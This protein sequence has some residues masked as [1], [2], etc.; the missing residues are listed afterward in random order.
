MGHAPRS[1]GSFAGRR[2]NGPTSGCDSHRACFAQHRTEHVEWVV[3]GSCPR[4]LRADEEPSGE[5]ERQHV[6]VYHRSQGGGVEGGRSE[7]QAGIRE[8]TLALWFPKTGRAP[9]S[10]AFLRGP[11]Q[12]PGAKRVSKY[13]RNVGEGNEVSKLIALTIFRTK[14]D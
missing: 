4:Q 7:V 13:R 12:R 9:E 2:R 6:V 10:A 5:A 11:V 14:C 3:V 1:S 8:A